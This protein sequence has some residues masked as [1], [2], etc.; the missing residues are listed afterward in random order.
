VSFFSLSL[1][2]VGYVNKL[3]YI[4]PSLHPWDEDYLILVNDGFD[5]FLDSVLKDLIE[6]VLLQYS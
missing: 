1:F 3:S 6:Y 5:V 4:E 2:I